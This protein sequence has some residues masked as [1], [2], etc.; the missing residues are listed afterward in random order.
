MRGCR[1]G[2]RRMRPSMSLLVLWAV[3][4][5][6]C[7]D[8]PPPVVETPAAAAT[9]AKLP[10]LPRS[11]IAA[12]VA[13]KAELG[14]SD[15]Q[16]R[17]LELRDQEREREDAA[18]RDEVEKKR[19][20]AQD[21]KANAAGGTGT[22]SSGGGGSSTGGGGGMRGG[23]MRGG[24][25]RGGGMG[26]GLRGP[27]GGGATKASDHEA[28]IQDRMDADDTKAY[29]DGENLLKP[30]QRDQAREIA[31]DFRAQLYERREAERAAAAAAR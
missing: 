28:S 23:G 8:D 24:G 22:G 12:V 1:S 10:P 5:G 27:I 26:R 9:P 14:L 19:K 25:M 20:Q 6:A 17:D 4:H 31:S 11:S 15:D 2:F 30:E 16:V 18:I 7:A 3:A 13:H 21:A 29:L